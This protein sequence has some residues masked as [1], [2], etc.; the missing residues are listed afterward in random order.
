[1]PQVKKEA[2]RNRILEVAK[3][4][5]GAGGYRAMSMRTVASNSGISTSNLY[6]YFS[7]KEA[8]LDTL[9]GEVYR[10]TLDLEDA[11]LEWPASLDISEFDQYLQRM[12]TQL[13][14]YLDTNHDELVLLLTKV[15][16]SP[17]EGFKERFV[18]HYLDYERHAVNHYRTI[19]S[20]PSEELIMGIC[21]LY[22]NLCEVYLLHGHNH[23][24]MKEKTAELNTFIVG[25][26]KESMKKA[27]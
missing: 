9:V 2:V 3:E 22:V 5:L 14:A 17:F 24:W 21:H 6:T 19:S 1:M 13:L 23:Q 16:G 12:T 4:E 15:Q 27:D 7:N 18:A 26:L 20:L 25:G 10:K 11:N 8:L